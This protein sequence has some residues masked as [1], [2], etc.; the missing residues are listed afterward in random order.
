MPLEKIADH[1]AN[2]RL[3]APVPIR[4]AVS[5]ASRSISSPVEIAVFIVLPLIIL[6]FLYSITRGRCRRQP[7]RRYTQIAVGFWPGPGCEFMCV[8]SRERAG[9]DR[10]RDDEKKNRDERSRTS[11]A[12]RGT[13]RPSLASRRQKQPVPEWIPKRAADLVTKERLVAKL[14]S[15]VLGLVDFAIRA[16]MDDLW[17]ALTPAGSVRHH[18]WLGQG[19]PD[20]RRSSGKEFHRA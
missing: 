4:R 3:L 12:C 9:A 5:S 20:P 19:R 16:L 18:P 2:S 10:F 17:W 14:S 8:V 15:D 11:R 6:S 7:Y 13:I 1:K